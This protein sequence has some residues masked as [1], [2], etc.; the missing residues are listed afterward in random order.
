MVSL[1]AG[2]AEQTA[3]ERDAH[4]SFS[5]NKRNVKANAEAVWGKMKQL[6]G[7]ANNDPVAASAS[8]D[9][10][11]D[12]LDMKITNIA[13]KE[14]CISLPRGPVRLDSSQ[15]CCLAYAILHPESPP[16]F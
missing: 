16:P 4:V 10:S 14:C 9:P 12:V 1:P 2:T 6:R 15:G 13:G 8:P 11:S 5:G 3:Q 7:E